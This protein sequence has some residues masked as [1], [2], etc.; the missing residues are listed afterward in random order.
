MKMKK[1]WFWPT[2]ERNGKY[3]SREKSFT[4]WFIIRMISVEIGDTFVNHSNDFIRMVRI[5][6]HTQMIY[7][8]K[9]LVGENHPANDKSFADD[10][11]KIYPRDQHTINF[12]GVANEYA[13]INIQMA[14]WT[15]APIRI[16]KFEIVAHLKA[17]YAQNV[18][19]HFLRMRLISW[20][21]KKMFEAIVGNYGTC[22]SE[23]HSVS[24][25]CPSTGF[26]F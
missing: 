1:S 20:I 25:A 2:F 15:Y 7:H 23:K 16:V 14:I 22:I 9:W 4:K 12:C 19:I 13:R 5:P 10:F 26:K 8:S 21:S 17:L 3:H 18:C 24:I 6:S 11:E